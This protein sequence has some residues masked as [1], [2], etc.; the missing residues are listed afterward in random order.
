MPSHSLSFPLKP[1][2][3]GF[4]KSTA[5]IPPVIF[6]NPTSDRHYTWATTKSTTLRFASALQHTFSFQ[7][8]DVLALFSPN[9]IDTPAVT[10]GTHFAGGVVS[11]AN[12]GYSPRELVH[13]LQDSGAKVLVTQHSL[14]NT[15]VIAA[16]EVGLP[17]SHILLI[18]EEEDT[19]RTS[20]PLGV[21]SWREIMESSSS[22]EPRRVQS[23][24]QDLAFL[25]YS[26]GTTG[27]PKGVML[28]HRNVVGVLLITETVEGSPD[29]MKTGRDRLLAVLPYYH[30]YGM[31]L[32]PF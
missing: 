10:W 25:V 4:I 12:P 22:V 7:P 27:V 17:L 1:S 26:S 13:H 6:R 16:K 9:C 15:A 29:A 19:T 2:H 20:A 3:A 21:R 18:G 31:F 32:S 5:N 28:T 23:K 30:I 24:P 14:L 11:P 8:T